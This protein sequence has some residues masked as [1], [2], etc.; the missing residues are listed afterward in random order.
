MVR[1]KTGQ[2][3]CKN[4][5]LRNQSCLHEQRAMATKYWPLQICLLNL[6]EVSVTSMESSSPYPS[7]PQRP[8]LLNTVCSI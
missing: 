8:N 1:T 3:V 6:G 4:H 2:A 7:F 5:T